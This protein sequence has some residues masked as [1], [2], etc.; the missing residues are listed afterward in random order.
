MS[1]IPTKEDELAGTEQPFVQH[2]MELR[3]RLVK[4]LIAIG[5]AAGILFLYPGPGALYDLLAAP[6][7][8]HL[9]KGATLIATSV[10][11][12]FMVPLKILLMSAFLVALPVVL[13]QVWAFVAPGLYSHEKKLV[14]PLVVSSTLLFLVGVAFCYFF[15]FGQVFAFIQSF[16]PKSITAAPDIEAYLSF[17]LT[18][19]LAFGLSFEVPIVVIVLARM[20]IVSV[21]KLKGFR[22]YFIVL[23]FIIAAVVT[24][25]D[26]VSQLALAVPMCLLYEL[27][28]WA[29][30]IFIRHTKAPEDEQA[31]EPT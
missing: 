12:P 25:P 3:D 21:E 26:V 23:A 17:V 24:P 1:E 6:L 19:F 11:S 29:A 16:A 31:Q 9:P 13:W 10:I 7:V 4:A 5:I 15:V 30:Q 2:L 8:A 28:I 18:M 22:G 14:L 20:G 27:G